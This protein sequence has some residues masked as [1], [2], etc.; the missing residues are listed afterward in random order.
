MSSK[1]LIISV[2]ALTVST[3]LSAT[4]TVKEPTE[5]PNLNFDQQ[6]TAVSL[7]GEAKNTFN[8]AEGNKWKVTMEQ[9][10]TTLYSDKNEPG[11]KVWEKMFGSSGIKG[12]D[13]NV[14]G[15]ANFNRITSSP[16]ENAC[17]YSLSYE[18]T[19]AAYAAHLNGA[20]S[21]SKDHTDQWKGQM[22]TGTLILTYKAPKDKSA[23][24]S[25]A[26]EVK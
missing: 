9:A 24:S 10:E 2:L 11:Y 17:K 26:E 7:V 21:I 18:L 19:D 3:S 1:K 22:H 16:N 14:S 4:P 5:C 25:K 6:K 15:I 13:I 8:D 12:S 20:D 23:T